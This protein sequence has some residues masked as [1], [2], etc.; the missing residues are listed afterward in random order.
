MA[1]DLRKTGDRVFTA[2]HG[3]GTIVCKDIADDALKCERRPRFVWTGR[4]GVKLDDES[5]C[6]HFTKG[7]LYFWPKELSKCP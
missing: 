1:V 7:V 4:W 6:R 2:T 3:A 5:L